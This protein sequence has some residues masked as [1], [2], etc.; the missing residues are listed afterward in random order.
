LIEELKQLKP[1][2]RRTGVAVLLEPLTKKETHYMNLQSHGTRIIEAVE[3]SGVKLL[4]DF[5]HMQMEES[6]IGE[7][8]GKIG[9]YTAYVHLADG[10][11]RTQPGSLP[12][13][14]RPGFRSLKKHNF[15]GW[16]MVESRTS[17]TPEAALERTV[18]KI[19][20]VEPFDGYPRVTP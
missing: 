16:L 3:S 14:Y 13:D 8:H 9:K 4:S 2:V 19:R 7:T 17:D 6:D 18:R 11:K 5:Y 1:D 15:S 12:F 20:R 10:E